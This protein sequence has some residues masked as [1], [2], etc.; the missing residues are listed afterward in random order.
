MRE[1]VV[2]AGQQDDVLFFMRSAWLRSPTYNTLFWYHTFLLLLIVLLLLLLIV[3]ISTFFV[4]YVVVGWVISSSPGMAMMVLSPPSRA[5][6]RADSPAARSLIAI[7]ADTTVS[8]HWARL[9]ACISRGRQSYSNAGQSLLHLAQ[10]TGF[11]LMMTMYFW[12][13]NIV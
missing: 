3:L 7:S 9:R 11:I 1:A 12:V 10:V 6:C 4:F 13:H 2:E 5:R 8:S